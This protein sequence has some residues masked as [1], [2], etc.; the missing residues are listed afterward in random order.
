MHVK[1]REAKVR[2]VW[3]ISVGVWT[4]LSL[5]LSQ[6]DDLTVDLS[7][8]QLSQGADYM[9]EVAWKA[10][11]TT[12][13]PRQQILYYIYLNVCMRDEKKKKSRME[14]KLDLGINE[15]TVYWLFTTFG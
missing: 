7:V 9:E 3:D 8:S 14:K 11:P 4:L 10:T 15:W 2:I 13:V 6:L 1:T 12:T 5:S